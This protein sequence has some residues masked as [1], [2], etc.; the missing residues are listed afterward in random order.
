MLWSYILSLK[1]ELKK[2]QF[3]TKTEIISNEIID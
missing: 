1:L 2:I 3:Y